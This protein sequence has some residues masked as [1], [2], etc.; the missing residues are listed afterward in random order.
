MEYRELYNTAWHII[1]ECEAD[2]ERCLSD[3]ERRDL[4][5]D[6][7]LWSSAVIRLLVAFIRADE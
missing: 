1:A 3:G 5:M 7:T 2:L 4:L 6:N